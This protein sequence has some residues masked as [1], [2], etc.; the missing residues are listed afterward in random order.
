MTWITMM[1]MMMKERMMTDADLSGLDSLTM[2][3]MHS[4]HCLLSC[5][6]SA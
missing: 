6:C 3:E 2:C 1:I 4:S 5:S